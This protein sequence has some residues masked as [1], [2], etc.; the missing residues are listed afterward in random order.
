VAIPVISV[1]QSLKEE[2][3]GR[4]EDID[5]L[6]HKGERKTARRA[7]TRVPT[8]KKPPHLTPAHPE[9]KASSLA[10]QSSS[11]LPLVSEK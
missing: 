2:G 9:V 3:D 6:D 4:T 10:F 7:R 1:G 8:K 5:F 11:V